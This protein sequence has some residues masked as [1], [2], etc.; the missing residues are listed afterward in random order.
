VSEEGGIGPLIPVIDVF[1]AQ[2]EATTSTAAEYR[3]SDG[4]KSSIEFL[5]SDFTP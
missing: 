2:A 4:R 1:V 5:G 3:L